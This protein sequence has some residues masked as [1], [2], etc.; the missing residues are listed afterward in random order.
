MKEQK[1]SCEEV[2][3][4]ICINL[5]EDL[6][7]PKCRAIKLHLNECPDCVSYLKS[8]KKTIDLYKEYPSPRPSE[9]AK[10]SIDEIIKKSHLSDK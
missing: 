6:D 2:H 8:L 5:D 1:L 4:H 3:E 10:V 9:S 7:S